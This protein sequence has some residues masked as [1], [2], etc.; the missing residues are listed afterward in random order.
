MKKKLLSGALAAAMCLTIPTTV[1]VAP[2]TAQVI[3][4]NQNQLESG[5]FTWGFRRSLVRYMEGFIAK[6]KVELSGPVK[7]EG[8]NFIFPLDAAN[9]HLDA[10]GNGQLKLLGGL[11]FLGHYNKSAQRWDMDVTI[12]NF[13][14]DVEGKKVTVRADYVTKGDLSKAPSSQDG[15]QISGKNVAFATF[16]LDSAI[17]PG[18]N[19]RFINQDTA[20]TAPGFSE[21]FLND[22]YATGTPVDGPNLKLVSDPTKPF[23]EYGKESSV[24]SENRTGV[25]IGSIVGVLA[26][27]GG[28]LG[29]LKHFGPQFGIRLPF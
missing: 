11:H 15:D 25:I 22:R 10:A 3:E 14:L 16:E 8:A 9:S 2:A 1:V 6:G 27:I 29:A 20:A 5:S 7:R 23:T 24:D 13:V 18:T 28:L 17:K 4:S 21:A 26:A 19:V 12:D